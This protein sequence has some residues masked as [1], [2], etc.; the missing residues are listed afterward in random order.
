LNA[1]NADALLDRIGD[2]RRA[3]AA[4]IGIVLPG[5]RLRDDPLRDPR[6]YAIRVRERLAGE[7]TVRLDALV[8]V[9][10]PR[11]LAQLPG[12]ET[13]E[14]VYGLRCKW[15]SPAERERANAAGALTFDAISIIGSH[16]SEIAR[17]NA[18]ELLGRQEFHTLI[19]HLRASVPSLVKDVGGDLVPH[20]TAHRVFTMLLRERVWPRDPIA[21]F[22]AI[23]DAAPHT[24]EPRDLAEAAR[25]ALVP[26]QLRR[27]GIT[28]L[29]PLI[30]AP[31]FESE[32][33]R[34][35][36]PGGGLAPDPATA[37]HVRECIA[38]YLAD[39]R[40]APHAVVVTAP[41]RPM[42]ADF[43]ERTGLTVDVYAFAELP[44]ELAIEPAGILDEPMVRGSVPTSR[45]PL[46]V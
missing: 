43:F 14:P 11:V 37:L 42:L 41:L 10:D 36:S 39:P 40:H 38:A 18:A 3:F 30:F 7:G 29:T 24:R 27:D 9:A 32:L 12:E 28:K 15:I 45:Q 46:P 22:E 31:A 8:A 16:L 23:V 17:R 5:V 6:T 26:Q 25:R 13:R 20:A 44:P 34:M 33:A 19:E 35:W 21:A 2:V 4:E 1:P